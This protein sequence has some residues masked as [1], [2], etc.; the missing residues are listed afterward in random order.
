[1]TAVIDRLRARTEHRA[2]CWV[3]LGALDTSG[4]GRIGVGP[5]TDAT[6]RVAYV[7]LVGPVPDG[8]QLD[9]LCG[10]RACW[11]PDHLEPVAQ[12]ENVRRGCA[13]RLTV[14]QADEIRRLA[15]AGWARADIAG[16]YGVHP[17]TVSKIRLGQ[18]WGEPGATRPD[19]TGAER[20]RR[21]RQ[22]QTSVNSSGGP[23]P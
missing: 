8:M 17:S 7:E 11:N 9:H 1:M 18:R 21:W 22:N 5:A 15:E 20:Q 3:W 6:H 10:N 16:A 4:Y 12:A 2:D 14:E 13:T 19:S 23:K